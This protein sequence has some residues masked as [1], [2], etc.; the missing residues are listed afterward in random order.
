MGKL[1]VVIS[2]YNE[3]EVIETCLQSVSWADEIVLIDNTS[4]D[5]TASIAK[6]FKAKVFKRPN[7]PMLNVNKNYG[8]TKATGDWILNLDADESVDRELQDEIQNILV[9][10]NSPYVGYKIPRKNMLFGKWIRHAG[11]YPDHQTRLF[12]RGT[13]AF[14]EKHVHEHIVVTGDVGILTGHIVHHSF[15]TVSQFI[16]KH[17]LYSSNEAENLLKDGYQ[18]NGY[19]SIRFPRREFMSR[20]FARE[21]YKDGLH[22]LAL[23]LL[24]AFYHLLIF[25][26]LWEKNHYQ[27]TA[28]KSTLLEKEFAEAHHEMSHW[29]FEV[30]ENKSFMKR[31]LLKL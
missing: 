20:Y 2:A 26:K 27:E 4:S 15:R 1:S 9:S 31:V 12:K 5:S 14:A 3:E 16:K 19:D 6:K 24:M 11:W 29:F 8:F 25:L 28:L 30:S 23:S 17:D 10:E 7:N 22:G 13:G 21:G 18:F